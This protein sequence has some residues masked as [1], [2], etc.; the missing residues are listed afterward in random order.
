MCKPRKISIIFLCMLTVILS[1]CSYKEFEDSLRDKTINKGDEQYINPSSVPDYSPDA[2]EE[3]DGEIL[4]SVG[5]TI[6]DTFDSQSVQYSLNQAYILDNINDLDLGVDDFAD[7]SLIL[8]D[9]SIE[10]PYQ[11][12]A[13]DITV[14][15]ISFEGYDLE[16]DEPTLF[17]EALVGFKDGIED[18]DGPFV[19]YASYF[20]EHPP[21][22]QNHGQ[23]YYQYNLSIDNEMN[24]IIG[25]FLPTEQLNEDTLYYIIGGEGSPEYFQYFELNFD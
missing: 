4:F 3:S 24:T 17:I 23:D 11:F 8:E 2:E 9:G 25:W 20:S 1:A 18:P 16:V 14:K 21:L 19:I 5:D 10:E 15:N 13:V 7:S 6:I 22:D 12:V